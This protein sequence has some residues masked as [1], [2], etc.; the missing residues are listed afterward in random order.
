MSLL[1]STLIMHLLTTACTL[2][3]ISPY[4]LDLFACFNKILNLQPLLPPDKILCQ[5]MEAAGLQDWRQALASHG[6]LVGEQQQQTAMI[7][8]QLVQH[9]SMLT[10]TQATMVA[11]SQSAPLL[12][13]HPYKYSGYSSSVFNITLHARVSCFNASCISP[14][15]REWWR[16]LKI[17]EFINL[18]TDKAFTWATTVWTHGG[19]DTSYYEHILELFQRFFNHS[20]KGKEVGEQV[21]RFW[22]GNQS[23][24]EFALEFGTLAD[25]SGWNKP[26]L[27]AAYHQGLNSDI[28]KELACCDVKSSFNSLIDLSIHLDHLLKEPERQTTDNFCDGNLRAWTHVTRTS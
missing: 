22:Q 2:T 8:A 10:L 4:I 6:C 7:N 16:G 21:L 17:T 11:P 25:G 24:A 20:P 3:L 13:A 27:K 9:S 28:L 12:I 14:I 18:L 19:E 23:T 26:A 5:H 15:K 1:F